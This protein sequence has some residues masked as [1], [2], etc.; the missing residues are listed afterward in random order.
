MDNIIFNEVIRLAVEFIWIFVRDEMLFH[1][2]TIE[3]HRFSGA[4]LYLLPSFICL[5]SLLNL[6]W[7]KPVF[8]AH[9]YVFNSILSN[10]AVA[11]S[12]SWIEEFLDSET[13]FVFSVE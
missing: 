11:F 12:L 10:C 5:L 6:E 13:T 2:E 3:S 7:V 8:S 9:L 4:R 1:L